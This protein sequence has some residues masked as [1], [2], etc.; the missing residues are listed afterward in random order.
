MFTNSDFEKISGLE[1]LL[2]VIIVNP[3]RPDLESVENKINNNPEMIVVISNVDLCNRKILQLGH[4]L[5]FHC[6]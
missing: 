5:G 6:V 1:L 3:V 2:H 4:I